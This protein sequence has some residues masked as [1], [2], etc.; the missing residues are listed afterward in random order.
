MIV[1]AAMSTDISAVVTAMDRCWLDRRYD[2]LAQYIAADVV[3]VA[4]GGQG[5]MLGLAAA[6]DSYREFMGRAEVSR[7]ETSDIRVTERG[8][9]AVVEYAWDMA[10]SDGG[11]RHEAT[12]REVLML[13]R[14]EGEWRVVWRTQLSN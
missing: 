14:R 13:A 10:W 9:A 11:E 5:R 6:I 3:M 8:D 12:G 7:Y 2:D 1:S 4:P